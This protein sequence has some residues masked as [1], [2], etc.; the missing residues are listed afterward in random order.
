[1][2]HLLQVDVAGIEH[3]S[4]TA[5]GAAPSVFR[6]LVKRLHRYRTP[7]RHVEAY[8]AHCARVFLM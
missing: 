1:M 5:V 6:G 7:R 3:A 4:A 2:Q 8:H